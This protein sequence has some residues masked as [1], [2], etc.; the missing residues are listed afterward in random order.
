[1]KVILPFSKHHFPIFSGGNI[2]QRDRVGKSMRVPFPRQY[3]ASDVD[4]FVSKVKDLLEAKVDLIRIVRLGLCAISFQDILKNGIGT[5]FQQK[6]PFV[7]KPDLKS[8]PP[9]QC[10]SQI[11]RTKNTIDFGSPHIKGVA[12]RAKGSIEKSSIEGTDAEHNTAKAVI[13]QK[14]ATAEKG[15][16][17]LQYAQ[18]LQALYD[19]E[20]DVLSSS[21]NGA[22]KGK[23]SGKSK[24]ENFF[25]KKK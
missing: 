17:D 18:K 19:R 4:G 21:T 12:K 20:N 24:I 5:F 15:D 11:Y 3:C 14:I 9:G 13:G 25:L 7:R 22:N 10:E 1:M 2:A 6:A 8:A 23:G 16:A